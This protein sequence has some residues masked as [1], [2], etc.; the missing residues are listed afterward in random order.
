MSENEA[1]VLSPETIS[2]LDSKLVQ[3]VP[4]PRQIRFQQMEF[5]AFIHFSVNTY[6]GKEWGDGT[7]PETIFQPVNFDADQWVNAVKA[8]GMKGLILTC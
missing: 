1:P 5:Y 2:E 3:I 7:E 6:T 4:S 8:A